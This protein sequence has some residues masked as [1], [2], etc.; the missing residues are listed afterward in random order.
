MGCR[1]RGG[2]DRWESLLWIRFGLAGFVWKERGK[3]LIWESDW[4]GSKGKFGGELLKLSGRGHWFPF[5]SVFPLRTGR[6]SGGAR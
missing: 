2:I 5:V 6:W 4:I 1:R 3:N